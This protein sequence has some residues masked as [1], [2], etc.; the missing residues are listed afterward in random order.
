MNEI[1]QWAV[2]C[3]AAALL[4]SKPRKAERFETLTEEDRRRM[5]GD[6]T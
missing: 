2:I 3:L 5:F 1:L 4:I 6:G